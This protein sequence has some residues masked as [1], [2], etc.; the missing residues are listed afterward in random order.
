MIA[1]YEKEVRKYVEKTYKKEL[2]RQVE[3][4]WNMEDIMLS[5]SLPSSTLWSISLTLLSSYSTSFIHFW[6]RNFLYDYRDVYFSVLLL[7][8]IP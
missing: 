8:I 1:E 5:L 2:V 6:A 4:E 7:F 3:E